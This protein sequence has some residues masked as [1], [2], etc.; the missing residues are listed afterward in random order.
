MSGCLGEVAAALVDGELDH[1]A[2]ERAHRHLARCGSCRA[3]VEAQ[4]RLK[5]ALSGLSPAPAPDALAG[6]LMALQ[7]PGTDRLG[8]PA[9]PVRPATVRPAAGPG[10]RRPRGRGLRRRTAVGTSVVALGLVALALGSPQSAAT[11]PVD[12]ATD[13]FVVEHV[14]TTSGVPRVVQAGLTGGGAGSPR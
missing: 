13:A 5:T 7:V 10:N 6:R 11:T 3:E 2:R 1:A 12:P 8:A 14:D 4:R 9:G